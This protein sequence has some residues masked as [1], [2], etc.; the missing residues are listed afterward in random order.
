MTE[1]PVAWRALTCKRHVCD[2]EPCNPVLDGLQNSRQETGTVVG[3]VGVKHGVV[4]NK[5][6]ECRSV[7]N[8]VRGLRAGRLWVPVIRYNGMQ[9]SGPHM[10]TRHMRSKHDMHATSGAVERSGQINGI[11]K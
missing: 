1:N 10:R 8:A 4:M 2:R 5:S 9:A 7:L 6:A 3:Q 11:R